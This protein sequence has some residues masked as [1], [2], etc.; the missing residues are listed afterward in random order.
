[1]RHTIHPW[2]LRKNVRNRNVGFREAVFFI[3]HMCGGFEYFSMWPEKVDKIRSHEGRKAGH[4]CNPELMK[5]RGRKLGVSRVFLSRVHL[6]FLQHIRLHR[7]H[8]MIIDRINENQCNGVG[9]LLAH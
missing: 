3:V 5:I 2:C 9:T 7:F 6:Q 8:P 4:L 1:M